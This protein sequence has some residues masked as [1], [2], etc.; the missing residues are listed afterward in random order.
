MPGASSHP[1]C[2]S[3][4]SGEVRPFQESR[5]LHR[6][7]PSAPHPTVL[8]PLANGC[9]HGTPGMACPRAFAPLLLPQDTLLGR[10]QG[11]SHFKSSPSA[12]FSVWPPRPARLPAATRPHAGCPRTARSLPMLSDWSP[13]TG[14]G[15]HG[16]RVLCVP[17]SPAPGLCSVNTCGGGTSWGHQSVFTACSRAHASRGWRPGLGAGLPRWPGLNWGTLCGAICTGGSPGPTVHADTPSF[18]ELPA[19]CPGRRSWPGRDR[20]AAGQWAG[21]GPWA[22]LHC[23]PAGHAPTPPVAPGP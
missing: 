19:S 21:A 7:G 8:C 16:D 15:L 1:P 11:S 6:L 17:L 18:P 4:R 3:A 5:R 2:S 12:A 22:A 20:V 9:S 14:R 13:C 23:P 10:P